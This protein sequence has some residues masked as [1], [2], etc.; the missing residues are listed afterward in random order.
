MLTYILS[1][2]NTYTLRT[3]PLGTVTSLTMSLQDM[4]L[5]TNSTASLSNITYDT[6]ES[7]LAF[8]ASLNWTTTGQEYRAKIINGNTEIWHGSLQVLASQSWEDTGKAT[9]RNQIPIDNTF[10][11]NVSENK[12]IILK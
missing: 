8:T 11:S 6:Y 9:Y 10:V 12:Y 7:L 4:T 1:G 5:L 3:E 2:S